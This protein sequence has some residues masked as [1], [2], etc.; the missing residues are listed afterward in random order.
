MAKVVYCAI[1]HHSKKIHELCLLSELRHKQCNGGQQLSEEDLKSLIQDK[2]SCRLISSEG[3]VLSVAVLKSSE[4]KEDIDNYLV[5]S[6]RLPK[7]PRQSFELVE[8]EI[9]VAKKKTKISK[10]QAV[11]GRQRKALSYSRERM[12]DNE[13]GMDL[14]QNIT[15]TNSPTP[16]GPKTR[17]K[18]R[19]QTTESRASYNPKKFKGNAQDNERQLHKNK[20][21][22]CNQNEKNSDPPSHELNRICSINS[23]KNLIDKPNKGSFNSISITSVQTTSLVSPEEQET[24]SG[25]DNSLDRE[26]NRILAYRK[27]IK[28][29]SRKNDDNEKFTC[30]PGKYLHDKISSTRPSIRQ[31]LLMKP[32]VTNIYD[33][34]SDEI[35]TMNKL[36]NNRVVRLR[37]ANEEANK[38]K[39]AKREDDTSAQYSKFD[40]LK[41]NAVTNVEPVEIALTDEELPLTKS[42]LDFEEKEPKDQRESSV[43]KSHVGVSKES[44][45]H[46]RH[47]TVDGER[48]SNPTRPDYQQL[49]EENEALKE[50]Q[51]KYD[52]ILQDLPMPPKITLG[53]FK[54]CMKDLLDNHGRPKVKLNADQNGMVHISER[55]SLSL[56]NCTTL[57]GCKSVTKRIDFV[58][59]H[60]WSET[61]RRNLYTDVTKRVLTDN[62]QAHGATGPDLAAIKEIIQWTQERDL[63]DT[64]KEDKNWEL[65]FLKSV[66]KKLVSDRDVWK[67]SRRTAEEKEVRK[68]GRQE[69]KKGRET[70]K[71]NRE[72]KK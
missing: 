64:T 66:N 43:G 58:V 25:S 72:Q 42:S 21:L 63:L 69:E 28:H 33:F 26:I 4:N 12:P 55:F 17:A 37:N 16:E 24:L 29:P 18:K 57:M 62:P 70:K 10:K 49:L 35:V 65:N 31:K 45:D 39:G 14:L 34:T 20:E 71:K 11:M 30:K 22:K 67:R 7:P 38:G 32:K 2:K 9:P 5:A 68:K 56:S 47:K 53:I 15:E 23:S 8:D 40:K 27:P 59:K 52:I 19:K 6:K 46:A 50:R 54:D 61:Y 60:F 51:K 36:R 1:W 41:I 48:L 13:H 44:R 3:K